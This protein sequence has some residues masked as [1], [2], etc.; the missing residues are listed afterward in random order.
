LAC[1]NAASQPGRRVQSRLPV[2]QIGGTFRS[3]MRITTYSA[4]MRKDLCVSAFVRKTAIHAPQSA[5]RPSFSHLCVGAFSSL[6]DN[7]QKWL[8]LSGG[9]VAGFGFL[10][11]TVWRASLADSAT[12]S[13]FLFAMACVLFLVAGARRKGPAADVDTR[14]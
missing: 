6:E 1:R 12:V 10:F 14:K 4:S 7:V 5:V 9:I 8:Y 11:L 13:A 3:G 2:A